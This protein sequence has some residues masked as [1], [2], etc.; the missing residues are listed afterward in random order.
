MTQQFYFPIS[1]VFG[2][3][4]KGNLEFLLNNETTPSFFTFA[5]IDVA[6][7]Y[8][9]LIIQITDDV[10]SKED[11]ERYIQ[12]TLLGS[13][14]VLVNE[15]SRKYWFRGF[16][17]LGIG[18]L[19]LLLPFL[20]PITFS[21][22][23]II[24]LL[25]IPLTSV[26]GKDSW[27][28]AAVEMRRKTPAMDSLFMISTVTAVVMSC[29]AFFIPGLPM[30][31]E[32]G[33]LIFGFR[34]LG[35]AM[36]QSIYEKEST[37]V[38]YE[39][40]IGQLRV[41][42]IKNHHHE[43]LVSVDQLQ[44][45]DK[46]RLIEDMP[47]PLD[48]WLIPDEQEYWMDVSRQ[49]GTLI[50]QQFRNNA[51]VLA[52]MVCKSAG[53]MQV[54][55]GH[56][57]K[58]F[59]KKPLMPCPRGDIWIYPHQYGI[60]IMSASDRDDQQV[61]FVVSRKELIDQDGHDHTQDILDSLRVSTNHPL[62]EHKNL[63]LSEPA[64]AQLSRAIVQHASQH[65]LQKTASFLQR[66]DQDVDCSLPGS[67][68][69]AAETTRIARFFVPAVLGTAVI[70]AILIG[71]FFSLLIAIRCTI[72][73][74]VSACPCTF[75][76][77][78]PLVMH[79]SKERANKFGIL[80]S[81][82]DVLQRLSEVDVVALDIHGTATKGDPKL[83]IHIFDE[84]QKTSIETKLAL[85]EHHSDHYL[86]KAIYNKV[87]GN[88]LLQGL[89]LLEAHDISLR[90]GGMVA[91]IEGQMYVLGHDQLM[92]NLGITLSDP[93][94]DMTYLIVKTDHGHQVL[95]TIE[96]RDELRSDTKLAVSQLKQRGY[97]VVVLSGA[98]HLTANAN[99]RAMG[100]DHV[101]AN[102]FPINTQTRKGKDTWIKEWQSKGHRVLMV[103]D[104]VN[105]AHAFKAAH[106]SIA[107]QHPGSDEGI[108]YQAKARISN[109]KME[110]VV[111]ALDLA[112]H[113]LW[114]IRLNL[115]FSLI[116][117]VM[118]VLLTNIMLLAYGTM[119]HPGVCAAVMMCQTAFI[120]FN[121][122]SLMHRPLPAAKAPGRAGLFGRDVS[123]PLPETNAPRLSES[124]QHS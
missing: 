59:S 57:L 65:G 42:R 53:V 24:A 22:K 29:V 60:H 90:Q 1:G 106:A 10:T 23:I 26:L 76:F 68:P 124:F 69:L 47:V 73:I 78:T 61:Q 103:G 30:M 6:S 4:C 117:N 34:H 3:C 56:Q 101:Y 16:L 43:E 104:G 95:A 28:E 110:A 122:Y 74:L 118:A 86:G 12:Q 77:I 46:I 58:Y 8:Q 14:Y 67:V 41:T 80:L 17:G 111:Q 109:Y 113:S 21:L 91:H 71:Y 49:E 20:I 19:I 11:V 38:Q 100:V 13:N 51:P 88:R 116:Y 44:P 96:M 112:H 35:I 7:N 107:M 84:L 9:Q 36:K 75:A 120:I 66:L 102:C 48:G 94:P 97:Q 63:H 93:H 62:N 87:G 72:A 114:T 37:P 81:Q 54:G 105:D 39:R 119:M 123:T 55:L 18:G 85:M 27:R 15:T 31:F 50:P 108:N 2:A 33:L 70:S 83:H 92:Q 5:A 79:F 32:T 99:A 64:R 25:G 45:G 98:S 121:A 40:L 82:E 89:S 52:G 115:L